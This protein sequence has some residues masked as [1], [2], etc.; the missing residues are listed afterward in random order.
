MYC[1]VNGNPGGFVD[2]GGTDGEDAQGGSWLS[3]G[4]KAGVTNSIGDIFSVKGA[5]KVAGMVAV[6]VAVAVI[7]PEVA[8][9]TAT[10]GAGVA[11]VTTGIAV[12]NTISAV[13]D[14]VD[15]ASVENK[16]KLTTHVTE[17]V[18]GIASIA[19]MNVG[20]PKGGSGKIAT[21]I[22]GG[23]NA[24]KSDGLKAASGMLRS[25]GKAALERL[26][27][28]LEGGGGGQG[29]FAF[30]GISGGGGGGSIAL[31]A[32]TAEAQTALGTMMMMKAVTGGGGVGGAG[33]GGPA[34][35]P[36]KL[37]KE[38]AGWL[39]DAQDIVKQVDSEIQ[40][41][42]EAQ[43]FKALKALGAADHDLALIQEKPWLGLASK[44]NIM[45]DIVAKRILNN[46]VLRQ[47]FEHVADKPGVFKGV[48][49]R[50]DF[51]LNG[52]HMV[53]LTTVKGVTAHLRRVGYNVAHFLTYVNPSK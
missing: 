1:Y 40:P 29:Q 19:A 20:G 24:L 36:S 44:G 28:V 25:A 6:G 34:H 31:S 50:P 33:K 39:A 10:I 49:G 2:K 38:E 7:L 3:R 42:L 53:E 41:L 5:L 26:D 52:K 16:E 15:N 51:R 32:T 47:V 46:P 17:A 4:L 12:V 21:K 23:I 22:E 48:A 43:D 9:V 14:V 45:E 37:T 30:A 11:I 35:N 8:A 27:G 18:V 13:K